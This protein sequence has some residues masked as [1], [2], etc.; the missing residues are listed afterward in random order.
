[1]VEEKEARQYL[2]FLF[3]EALNLL[4]K[5]KDSWTDLAE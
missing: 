4:I 5:K 1:V 2:F 3:K